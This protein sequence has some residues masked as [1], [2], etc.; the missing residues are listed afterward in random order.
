MLANFFQLLKHLTSQG[1]FS[2]KQYGVHFSR[3]LLI[4]IVERVYQALDK[5]GEA[6]YIPK[7]FDKVFECRFSQMEMLWS[8]R[9]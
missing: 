5:N 3:Q 4:I 7:C 8:F 9:M 6:L 1:L 2:D